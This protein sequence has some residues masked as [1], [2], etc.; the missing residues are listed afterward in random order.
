MG[1]AEHAALVLLASCDRVFGI[2]AVPIED[3]GLDA[4]P[5]APMITPGDYSAHELLLVNASSPSLSIDQ[6]VMYVAT[7]PTISYATFSTGWTAATPVA[8]LTDAAYVADRTALAYDGQELYFTRHPVGG[9][10]DLTYSAAQAGA[11]D[12]WGPIAVVAFPSA[13]AGNDVI[14][15]IPSADGRRV[16]ASHGMSG[17]E[18][19]AELAFQA[20]AWTAL[21]TTNA[22]YPA[23]G[24]VSDTR[25][26]LSPDGCAIVFA[27]LDRA[28]DTSDHDVW[29]ATRG[30]DGS[31][32]APQRLFT[33]AS[34]QDEQ[35]PWL[36]PDAASLYYADGATIYVSH[37]ALAL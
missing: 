33:N 23:G 25:A 14:Y 18:H 12:A 13:I 28:V 24:D 5:C 7:S 11:P 21:D 16:I 29:F 26:Q 2:A 19:L 32:V 10:Y 34:T 22:L 4:P 6:R 37:R 36:S 31:F 1:R 20:G 15:G 9:G 30:A 27:R 8:P 3:A 17:H 35:D